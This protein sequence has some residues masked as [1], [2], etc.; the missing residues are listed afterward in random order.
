MD[1]DASPWRS[2]CLKGDV[3]HGLMDSKYK[4]THM[5]YACSFFLHLF[6]NRGYFSPFYI[7]ELRFS[8]KNCIFSISQS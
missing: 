3:G 6:Q 1:K 4:H 2:H 7:K 5:A 8:E